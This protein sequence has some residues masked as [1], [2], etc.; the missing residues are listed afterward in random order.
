VSRK[1]ECSWNSPFCWTIALSLAVFLFWIGWFVFYHNF[2]D[3][4]V[5][6]GL[7]KDFAGSG[8]YGDGFGPLSALFTGLGFVALVYTILL[9]QEALRKQQDVEQARDFDAMFFR[10]L[11][12]FELMVSGMKFQSSEQYGHAAIREIGIKFF[13]KGE[14]PDSLLELRGDLSDYIPPQSIFEVYISLFDQIMRFIRRKP[15]GDQ[16]EYEDIFLSGL[17]VYEKRL[18]IIYAMISDDKVSISI[19]KMNSK[20]PIFDKNLISGQL[21]VPESDTDFGQKMDDFFPKAV[22]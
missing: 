3:N 19:R 9:Q 17:S 16:K 15:D 14:S 2:F 4:S 20:N 10:R 21:A 22:G 12:D 1:R 7:N 6:E 11:H 18:I 13:N 8:N 5:R